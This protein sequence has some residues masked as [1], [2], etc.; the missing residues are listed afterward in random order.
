M[1]PSG[2][3][4]Q[5]IIALIILTLGGFSP[6]LFADDDDRDEQRFSVDATI[7]NSLNMVAQGRNIFRHDTYG[8]EAFWGD[9]LRLHEALNQ[10]TPRQVLALGLKVDANALSDSLR[11]KIRNSKID[12]DD[13]AV[14][15]TL[16]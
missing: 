13:P 8:D 15:L 14:T 6:T 1:K 16:L 5:T 11:Q 10:L 9:T 3:S 12:L 7:R 4:Q 2:S